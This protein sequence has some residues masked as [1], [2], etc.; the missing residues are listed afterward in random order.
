[1][2]PVRIILLYL[3]ALLVCAPLA[4]YLLDSLIGLGRIDP[5]TLSTLLGGGGACLMAL[6]QGTHW[7]RFFLALIAGLGL[8]ALQVYGIAFLVLQTS[9]L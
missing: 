8:V 2:S 4:I 7:G 9:Q 1:M 3:G 6:S 5:L